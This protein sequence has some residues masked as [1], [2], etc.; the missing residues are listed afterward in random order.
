M[1][2][3][4][5]GQRLGKSVLNWIHI[6]SVEAGPKVAAILSAVESCRRLGL[7]IRN[8]LAAALPGLANRSVKRLDDLTPCR[9]G[10]M[11][12]EQQ[13][14]QRVPKKCSWVILDA[15]GCHRSGTR[16]ARNSTTRMAF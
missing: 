12:V 1:E 5:A 8:C 4:G 14:I 6:G 11:K 16:F 3:L 9:I 10:R 13:P 15:Y 2:T 7:P